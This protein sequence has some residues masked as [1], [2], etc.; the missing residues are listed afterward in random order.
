M[1]IETRKKL[2]KPPFQKV[3]PAAATNIPEVFSARCAENSH[4]D[5]LHG[6]E[7]RSS[8]CMKTVVMTTKTVVT[9]KGCRPP[10]DRVLYTFHIPA[11][12]PSRIRIFDSPEV[13]VYRIVRE[14]KIRIDKNTY[15]G[16]KPRRRTG[17]TS[18]NVPYCLQKD[19]PKTSG[20]RGKIEKTGVIVKI[21]INK[22][23]CYH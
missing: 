7:V 11:P 6:S 18:Q 17:S 3:S 2:S 21:L 20:F 4:D 15:T 19:T 23:A 14:N 8:P 9:G 12:S 16:N 22:I 5:R 13:K 10:W 1:P